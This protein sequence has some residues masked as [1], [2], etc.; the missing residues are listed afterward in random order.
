MAAIEYYFYY[1]QEEPYDGFHQ[2]YSEWSKTETFSTRNA[3]EKRLHDI[4]E[5]NNKTERFFVSGVMSR[6][7]EKH[8]LEEQLR[9]I[10]CELMHR[11]S[12]LEHWAARAE[13]YRKEIPELRIKIAELEKK[14]AKM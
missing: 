3:A 11:E 5:K 9:S 14:L 6:D 12:M 4:V 13:K 1:G 8:L 2:P 10:K 7:K